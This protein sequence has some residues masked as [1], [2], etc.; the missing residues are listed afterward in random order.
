MIV[1]QR[2]GAA[3]VAAEGVDRHRIG[4][5]QAANE[6]R[7][8][9]FGVDEAFVHE[10]AGVEEDEY[11]GADESVGALHA[12]QRVL[13]GV[14]QRAGGTVLVHRQGRFGPF[15]ERG[16]LLQNAVLVDAEISGLESVDVVILVVGHLEAQH[17]HVH[18]DAED[19]ALPVL[20]AE[21]RSG[22]AHAKESSS[23]NRHDG[24]PVFVLL[25]RSLLFGC[26]GRAGARANV[27]A[28]GAQR[29]QNRGPIFQVR[30]ENL[31]HQPARPFRYAHVELRG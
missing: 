12:G 7:D 11:V 31:F 1:R 19:G 20:G 15:G 26:H 24:L 28:H 6:I 17:H 22:R 21:H 3:Q 18:L 23:R 5:V 4:A 2:G 8:G 29:F 16:D 10:V 30:S 9:V 25:Q 13:R 14:E 27:V